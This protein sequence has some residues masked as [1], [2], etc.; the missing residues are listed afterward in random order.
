[1]QRSGLGARPAAASGRSRGYD[2]GTKTIR[3]VL[4]V[5]FCKMAYYEST[6]KVSTERRVHRIERVPT[7]SAAFENVGLEE[8]AGRS[9]IRPVRISHRI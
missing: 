7:R 4:V 8:G 6:S 5:A 2:N 9:T 3:S 1:V